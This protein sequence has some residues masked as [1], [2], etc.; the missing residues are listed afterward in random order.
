[1]SCDWTEKI[2][3][4]VDGELPPAEAAAAEAHLAGCPECRDARSEFLFFR[5]QLGSYPADVNPSAQRRALAAILAS[6]EA[7]SR[8]GVAPRA[9]WERLAA[10]L[11]VVRLRPA[12]AASLA[13][14][15]LAAAIGFAVYINSRE[16]AQTVV[17]TP[18]ANTPDDRAAVTTSPTPSTPEARPG[19]AKTP[20]RPSGGGATAAAGGPSR[21][22][23][24][25]RPT[26]PRP[27]AQN[28]S[29]TIAA[30]TNPP[31]RPPEVVHSAAAVAAPASATPPARAER[32]EVERA[33]LDTSRHVEQAQLLLRSFR[34]ARGS[35]D[36]AYER[37]RSR[38]LLYR[39]IVLR[40]EA[41]SKGDPVVAGVLD[42]LEPILLDI[43]NL[44]DKPASEDVDSIR[45]RVRKKNLVVALQAGVAKYE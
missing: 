14:F 15:V 43:A 31:T 45:E 16:E 22:R 40:R 39:N 44:P 34:N 21:E 29:Q 12:A 2:S 41:A 25:A 26:R 19:A 18:A 5:R 28:G 32:F 30:T 37:E 8:G 13:L 9:G 23:P 4:L 36:L 3:L 17:Q 38:R 27:A 1:M 42:R 35:D 6:K 10:A 7:A 33:A 11:G 20:D 24:R